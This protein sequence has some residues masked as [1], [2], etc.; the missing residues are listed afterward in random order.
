MHDVANVVAV[1]EGTDVVQVEVLVQSLLIYATISL[2]HLLS[3][4]SSKLSSRLPIAKFSDISVC[5]GSHSLL[6][7]NHVDKTGNLV[8]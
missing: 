7:H 3:C 8:W 1:E 2:C 4:I 5:V 6:Y